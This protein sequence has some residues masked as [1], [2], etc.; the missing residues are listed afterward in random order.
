MEFCPQKLTLDKFSCP[1]YIYT[2]K[3]IYYFSNSFD[4]IIY[5]RFKNKII[6]ICEH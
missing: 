1:I 3:Y 6:K 2:Y 5:I 4:I